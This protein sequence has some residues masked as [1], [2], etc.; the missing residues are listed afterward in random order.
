MQ[1]CHGPVRGLACRVLEGAD[2]VG[3]AV[4]TH[5]ISVKWKQG[6]NAF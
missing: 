3:L 5:A 6:F 1:L 4:D 2:D